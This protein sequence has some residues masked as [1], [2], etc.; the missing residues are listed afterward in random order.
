MA[1]IT[2]QNV[3]APRFTDPSNS[4]I[5][6]GQM[7]GNAFSGLQDILKQREATINTNFNQEKVGNFQADMR[8][9]MALDTPEK[10]AAAKAAGVFDKTL[11]ARQGMTDQPA[12]QAAVNNQSVNLYK[13][14]NERNTY[15]TA[16]RTLNEVAPISAFHQEYHTNP[17]EALKHLNAS[18]ILDKA[19]VQ[20]DAIKQA[21]QIKLDA[22]KLRESA[23]VIHVNE[24]QADNARITAQATLA[25]KTQQAATYASDTK[26]KE[27]AQEVANQ[28]L[29]LEQNGNPYANKGAA[30][31]ASAAVIAEHLN[32]Q[33][34]SKA[35]D[36]REAAEISNVIKPYLQGVNFKTIGADGKPVSANIPVPVG[37]LLSH[38]SSVHTQINDMLGNDGPSERLTALLAKEYKNPE[39]QKRLTD[40]YS[41]FR[42]VTGLD[43]TGNTDTKAPP[44]PATSNKSGVNADK[45]TTANTGWLG[46]FLPPSMGGSNPSTDVVANPFMDANAASVPTK[47]AVVS[48]L[49]SAKPAKQNVQILQAAAAAANPSVFPIMGMTGSDTPLQAN[50]LL[51]VKVQQQ[52]VAGKTKQQSAADAASI[53][54]LKLLLAKSAESASNSAEKDSARIKRL[55][56]DIVADNEKNHARKP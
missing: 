47:A 26:I 2:W 32:K 40:Q 17:V 41:Q 31:G 52:E 55:Y 22:A 8:S 18:A 21:T 33:I 43:K 24:A 14:A 38:I 30:T 39:T 37:E 51:P 23:S 35:I 3:D 27:R 34:V 1:A 15:D 36:A 49:M 44:V 46:N 6:A 19:S 4:M 13:Q 53:A 42:S 28:N 50:S 10:F 54:Q 9:L 45:L 20:A 11:A 7:M 48:Q 12:Y 5:A 56:T 29:F 25:Q 16:Q